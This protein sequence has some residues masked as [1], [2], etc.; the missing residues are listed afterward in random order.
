MSAQTSQADLIASIQ[1]EL[2]IKLLSSEA[3]VPLVD[4]DYGFRLIA[5]TTPRC[6]ARPLA[7]HVLASH[8]LGRIFACRYPKARLGGE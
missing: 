8:G 5:A 1:F 2:V 3:K 4:L 6:P 7:H